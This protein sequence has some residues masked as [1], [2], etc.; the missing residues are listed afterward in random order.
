MIFMILSKFL[1]IPITFKKELG[2]KVQVLLR[3]ASLESAISYKILIFQKIPYR[4]RLLR[5]S[6]L[7]LLIVYIGTTF[8]VGSSCPCQILAPF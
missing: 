6:F 2:L 7:I 8:G 3:F 5:W 4:E 1:R